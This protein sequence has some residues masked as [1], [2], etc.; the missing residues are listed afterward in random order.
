M[1]AF[2]LK[3][4]E[5]LREAVFERS[6]AARTGAEERR[7]LDLERTVATVRRDLARQTCTCGHAREQH[8]SL[9]ERPK[10]R[11]CV[12]RGFD[13]ASTPARAAA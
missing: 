4:L 9:A 7:W 5:M 2:T 11:V 12:C 8:P 6:G 1:R 13:A 10:C 3:E